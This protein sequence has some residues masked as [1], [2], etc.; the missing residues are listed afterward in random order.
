MD[1]ITETESV[2]CTAWYRSL[3]INQFN[4]LKDVSSSG[5]WDLVFGKMD[6]NVSEESILSE[7]RWKCGR[8]EQ[9]TVNYKVPHQARQSEFSFYCFIHYENVTFKRKLTYTW[10]KMFLPLHHVIY[11]FTG[12]RCGEY[13][14]WNWSSSNNR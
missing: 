12:R 13:N 1:F 9:V 6:T 10:K 7:F 11:N 14:C 3:N 2:S 4:V 5:A 8:K